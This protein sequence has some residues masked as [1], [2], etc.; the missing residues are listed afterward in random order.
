[1]KDTTSEIVVTKCDS[2]WRIFIP[3]DPVPA[4]RP[5]MARRSGRVYYGKKYNEFRKTAGLL[6]SSIDMPV[7]FPLEGP[8]AVSAEFTI[9]HPKKT[10]RLA[11]RGDVD[12]YF[13]TL[14]VLNEVVWWDDDQIL[15]ASMSKRYGDVTG[16]LLEVKRIDSIPETRELSEMWE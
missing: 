11:P 5:R 8:I 3:V 9:A 16:I 15:W 2:S 14:D 13:K 4:S 1:M 6:L 7:E 12:N 10:K